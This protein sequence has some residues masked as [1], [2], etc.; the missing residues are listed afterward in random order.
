MDIY[1]GLT[2][3]LLVAIGAETT[4]LIAKQ[5]S[6]I[7]RKGGIAT[8][9][10]TSVLIDGRI[11]S[12]ARAGFAG[13]TLIVPRSVVAELQYM[14][15][16]ADHDKRMRARYG[17]DV[18]Q[19][20]QQMKGVTVEVLQDPKT[21][22][23]DGQLVILAKQYNAQLCTIDYN[24]NKVAQVEGITVLN[25]NELAQALRTTHLPGETY[26][27][28]L[29]QKGSDSHQGVG[30]L[31]DGTMVVVEQSSNLIGKDVLVEFT[32]VLQTQA[33]RMMFARRVEDASARQA[34]F[35]PQKQ[36]KKQP[37]QTNGNDNKKPQPQQSQNQSQPKP[38][39]A[40]PVNKPQNNPSQSQQ[41]NWRKPKA[42]PED[43]LIALANKQK[44]GNE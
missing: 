41:N 16:N 42:T 5:P 7:R 38:K 28:Q 30:Y 33:G 11:V 29:V 26:K 12:V 22:D 17:L 32:R 13:G 34:N 31:E 2:L 36:P 21:K 37:S 15:D 10:D 27:L 4:Y 6:T 18:I 25:V 44:D 3:G 19:E 8:L 35:K 24:L 43:S 40:T 1:Q 14:A 23:V 39:P 9:V 20:L